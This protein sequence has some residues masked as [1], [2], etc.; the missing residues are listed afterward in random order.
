MAAVPKDTV[1]KQNYQ[2]DDSSE[3]VSANPTDNTSFEEIA[4]SRLSRRTV[5]QGSLAVAAAGY[6]APK[7]GHAAGDNAFANWFRR[8][9]RRSSLLDFRPLTTEDAVAAGGRT[10]TISPDFEYDV[11]IPWG[12]PIDPNSGIAEYTGDPNTRP[13]AAEQEQMIGIGHDGMWLFPINLPVVLRIEARLRRELPSWLRRIF[14]SSRAGV[15]CINHEFGNNTHVTGKP[16]PES[17]EDVRLSQHAHGVSV[18]AVAQRRGK[19][20]LV[21]NRTNRRITVNTEVEFSG[22]VAHSHLLQN[23][24]GNTFAG[25]VNNCG[26]GPTPWGTYLTCEE[27]FNG[28]FGSTQEDQSFGGFDELQDR[29]YDRYGFDFDGF[30]YGWEG[31]DPRF[32]LSNPDYANESNRF[33]WIVEIDPFDPHAKPI[34][35]TALGRFK[36]EAGAVTEISGGR[37]AVYMGDDQR[38]DYMYKYESRRSWRTEISR[39]RS[40]L[41]DGK[42]YVAKFDEDGSNEGTGTGQWIELTPTN[43]D[44]AAA[45]LTDMEKVLTYARIAGDAVGATKMD[46]PEWSTIGTN[47][48]VYWTLTNN[49]RKDDGQGALGESNPI[50]ENR[51]GHIITTTD[52]S[53]TTF[54]WNLFILARNTRTENPGDDSDDLPFAAYTAPADGGA[55]EFTDP[56]AAY[57]DPFGRL[58]IGTDGGQPSGLQDQLTVFDTNTGEYRRLLMGVNSD[59]ITGITFTPNFQTLFTNTQHPGNGNPASTNFPAPDDGV[60]IP[61][62]ATLVVRRKY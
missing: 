56:D 43:P 58:Y 55:N 49:D 31:F 12:T 38:G 44:I 42:L 51:D 23:A 47:G 2:I 5:M 13:T 35:R 8:R 52:T 48:E 27:N 45:G 11:L 34:K 20:D 15:L 30:G 54:E 19:W 29:G 28:Y 61:R 62:D 26:S 1:S 53:T 46:R 25:T 24:A 59:E 57:A 60:T 9:P 40:P 37:V 50:F 17:L 21:A 14:L 4:K 36:H 33:G 18:V 10:V 39:G 22:P 3:D 16:S 32:D 41:D 7:P 6:L